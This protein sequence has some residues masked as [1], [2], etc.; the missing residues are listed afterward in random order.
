MLPPGGSIVLTSDLDAFRRYLPYVIVVIGSLCCLFRLREY[1]SR[2]WKTV[3]TDST[4][5]ASSTGKWLWHC[6]AIRSKL[7]DTKCIGERRRYRRYHQRNDTFHPRTTCSSINP[8]P[9]HLPDDAFAQQQTTQG[10]NGQMHDALTYNSEYRAQELGEA[11]PSASPVTP[12]LCC[13]AHETG[14]LS[15]CRFVALSVFVIFWLIVVD[16]VCH[17]SMST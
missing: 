16:V 17:S 13:A 15:F 14:S 12:W 10:T 11:P 9:H 5:M 1:R 4:R 3:I 8:S 2:R 6:C 7:F